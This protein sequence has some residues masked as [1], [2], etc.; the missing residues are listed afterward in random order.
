MS[1]ILTYFTRLKQDI[2]SMGFPEYEYLLTIPGFGPDV[3]SK[4]LGAIGD[5]HRFNNHRQVLKL[6]GMDLSAE[7]SG[8]TSDR[9]VPVIS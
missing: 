5:P 9:A 7:R 6:A 8:M 3:S 4:V 2:S 1:R